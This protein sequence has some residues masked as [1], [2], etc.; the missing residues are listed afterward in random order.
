MRQQAK[1]GITFANP[2]GRLRSGLK[3]SY[4]FCKVDRD[5]H[6]AK[7]TRERQRQ[8]EEEES[9]RYKDD[10]EEI[11]KERTPAV[12]KERNDMLNAFVASL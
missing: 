6:K 2:I 9:K 7:E 10:I 12:M 8:R 11:E 4:P 1:R 5:F 3:H